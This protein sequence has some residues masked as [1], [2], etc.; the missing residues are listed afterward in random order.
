[1]DANLA[2][3]KIKTALKQVLKR[4]NHQY[5]DVAKLWNCSIPTVKRQLGTEELP[6]SRLL[7]LLEWLDLSLTDLHKLAESDT[8]SNPRFTAK[9]TEFL[10]KN[11]RAFGVLMKIYESMTP[12]QIAKK[13]KIEALDMDKLM[14]QLEKHDLIRVAPAGRVKPF[15]PV[16]PSIDGALARVT[17]SRQIDCMA[18]YSKRK[19]ELR[20]AQ[21][22]R[23]E[24]VPKGQYSWTIASMSEKTYEEF[25]TTFNRLNNDYAE[26][27]KLEEKTLKKS[28]LRKSVISFS[29]QLEEE[30]SPYLQMVEEIFA[31]TALEGRTDGT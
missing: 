30:D 12:A 27:A 10:A 14:I 31:P 16:L 21:V 15:Y 23:G 8:L 18:A 19:I 9:Q 4:N 11:L 26:R 17:V 28:E 6:V 2:Q 5:S 25:L 1:M 22:E 24:K 29:A 20:L 3:Q 13:Y 7:A